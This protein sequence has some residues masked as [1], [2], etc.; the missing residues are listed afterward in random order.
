MPEVTG[1]GVARQLRAKFGAAILL[2]AI[3]GYD[4]TE[5]RTVSFEAGFDMHL[6]KPVKPD[7]IVGIAATGSR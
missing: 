4:S 3:T 5:D 2:V 7:R 6:A 1:Y